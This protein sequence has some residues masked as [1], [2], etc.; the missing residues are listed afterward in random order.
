MDCPGC[1][2]KRGWDELGLGRQVGGFWRCRLDRIGTWGTGEREEGK[3][4]SACHTHTPGLG[5]ACGSK[6]E[7]ACAAVSVRVG[8]SV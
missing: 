1:I 7:R 2:D 5:T 8:L 6:C 4:M 3:E